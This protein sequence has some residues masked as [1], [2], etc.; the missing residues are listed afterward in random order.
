M[1]T[2]LTYENDSYLW[3]IVHKCESFSILYLALIIE[4]RFS[5]FS[6]SDSLF[7]ARSN[8]E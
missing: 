7:V 1:A 2:K 4:A 6:A 3:S 8:E 5:N